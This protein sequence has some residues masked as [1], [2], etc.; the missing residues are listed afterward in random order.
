MSRHP[1]SSPANETCSPPILT[2]G[3]APNGELHLDFNSLSPI[4][5]QHSLSNPCT[6]T[7]LLNRPTALHALNLPMMTSLF[8]RVSLPASC[9]LLTSTPAPRPAFSAGGDVRALYELIHA[10]NTDL[11]DL[12]FRTEFRLD[13]ELSRLQTPIIAILD[14]VVMGGGVGLAIHGPFR[15]ATE[16]ALFAMPETAIGIVPD[17]GA[18]YFLSRMKLPGL[19][20]YIALAGGRLKGSELVTAGVAT[21]FVSKLRLA[22]LISSLQSECFEGREG[23]AA[24]LNSFAERKEAHLRGMEVLERCFTAETVEATIRR[25]QSFI[26]EQKGDVEFAQD[27]LDKIGRMCPISLKISHEAQRRGRVLS[28]EESLRMEFRL[29]ARCIRRVDFIEGIRAVLIRKD[30]VAEWQPSR[31]EDIS[32]KDIT[33]F[34]EPLESDLKISE[35]VL[36]EE[37][38]R[39]ENKFAKPRL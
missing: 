28:V 34:F 11:A 2:Y 31:L 32:H 20:M 19:G 1:S 25:L 35:L 21:H 8:A 24:L 38:K 12:F 23:V 29:I 16:D 17:V 27:A 26:R 7:L 36:T 4:L 39:H 10:R 6:R 9:I 15:I 5:E 18:S 30:K 14:G 33:R 37:D 22:E 13:Y 3:V